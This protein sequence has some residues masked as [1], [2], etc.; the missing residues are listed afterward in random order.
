[1]SS[2][3]HL[4]ILNSTKNIFAQSLCK[5]NYLLVVTHDILGDSP[6]QAKKSFKDIKL[7]RFEY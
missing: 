2:Y 1:M 5:I 7:R 3:L 6:Q 4:L